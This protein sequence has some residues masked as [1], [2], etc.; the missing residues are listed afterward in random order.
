[1][2]AVVGGNLALAPKLTPARH[3]VHT[4]FDVFTLNPLYPVL[5][6]LDALGCAGK[7]KGQ[8]EEMPR[9]NLVCPLDM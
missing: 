7:A 2:R 1:M 3:R 8:E 6:Q 4:P 5:H 9:E